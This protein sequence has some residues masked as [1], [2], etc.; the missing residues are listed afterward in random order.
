MNTTM[1]GRAERDLRIKKRIEE[2]IQNKPKVFSEYYVDLLGDDRSPLTIKQYIEKIITFAESFSEGDI[3]DDFY[4]NVTIA[5]IK[6]YLIHIGNEDSAALSWSALNSFY[7]FLKINRNVND[8][9]IDYIKRPKINKE[10]EVVYLTDEEIAKVFDKIRSN[11]G[12]THYHRDMAIMT[13]F[14]TTGLRCNALAQINISDIDFDNRTIK[15][16]EK[17][18]R[19]RNIEYGEGMSNVLNEWMKDRNKRYKNSETDALFLSQEKMRISYDAIRA[20]VAKYTNGI[21][22]HITPHKLRSTAAT[23]LASHGANVQTI[24]EVLGHRNI[25]TTMRYVTAVDEEKRQAVN[26]LDSLITDNE[27]RTG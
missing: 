15:V 11:Q 23:S 19:V 22:K 6:S 20:I 24:R 12:K 18:K 10:H 8:N 2:K 21:D 17:G 1:N 7:K 3:K 16:V 5:D 26:M 14:L 9:P 4:E 27:R 25:Q 13:L